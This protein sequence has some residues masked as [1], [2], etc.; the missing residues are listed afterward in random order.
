M[1]KRQ[2]VN[3]GTISDS[4]IM[5]ATLD[6]VGLENV[7]GNFNFT[8][9]IISDNMQDGVFVNGSTNPTAVFN[10]T[11]NVIDMNVFE[12]IHFA[13]FEAANIIL[14]GNQTSNNGRNG[15]EIDNAL[16]SL[17]TGTDIL[18]TNHLADSNG[19]SGVTIEEGSGSVAVVGGT[20]T[21]CLLYTSP[22]PRD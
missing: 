22:S 16:N 10:F 15:V 21:N 9:N 5:G 1:Y 18:L 4:T 7:A 12:G 2:G 13:N 19:G 17:G 8:N 3:G 6:G 20:F 11:N 14:N